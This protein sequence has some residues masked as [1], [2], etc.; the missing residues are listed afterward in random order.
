MSAQTTNLDEL[1][2]DCHT[3]LYKKKGAGYNKIVIL[4]E[5]AMDGM[6]MLREECRD[7]E[8]NFGRFYEFPALLKGYYLNNNMIV[9]T[10]YTLPTT[11]QPI[12]SERE[13]E[14]VL[15]KGTEPDCI[16]VSTNNKHYIKISDSYVAR[17][18]A[19]ALKDGNEIVG[20]DHVHPSSPVPSPKDLKF[21]AG[22]KIQE[23]TKNRILIV[24]SGSSEAYEAYWVNPEHINKIRNILDMITLKEKGIMMDLF[25]PV[26]KTS[27]K[28]EIE[29]ILRQA[30]TLNQ[31][32]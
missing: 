1:V 7:I 28:N 12:N 15:K 10:G 8:K 31:L 23:G 30:Y 25:S 2:R 22:G 32:R 29:Y 27:D 13:L 11:F 17:A 19:E 16:L 18:W 9:V 26:K 3:L 6:N 5:T 4:T 24:Q 14:K 21:V 20:L